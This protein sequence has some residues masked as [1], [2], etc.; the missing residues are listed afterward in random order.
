MARIPL[1]LD[2]VIDGAALRRKL[3][4]LV[5]KA[6]LKPDEK[7]QK[8]LALFKQTLADGR[9]TAEKMLM[10]DGGGTTCAMRLSHLMDEIIRALYDFAVK[11]S[12]VRRQAGPPSRMAVVAIGGYGRGTLAP[13]SDIDLL[14]L[15]PDKQTPLGRAGRRIHALHA[16]GHRAEGRPCHAQHRRMHQAVARRH[17]DPHLDPGSALPVGASRRCSTI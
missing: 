7:R 2:D 16:V 8:A 4:A 12:T 1:K 13:G 6:D 15:L 11:Q 5:R 3:D 10:E 17:D 14:F 9:R